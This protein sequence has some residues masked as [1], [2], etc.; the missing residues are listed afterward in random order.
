MS[1]KQLF[2]IFINSWRLVFVVFA[3]RFCSEKEK[4]DKAISAWNAVK[5]LPLKGEKAIAYYL[6]FYK[7]FRNLFLHRIR[8][9]CLVGIIKI[10]FPPMETL[11][12][13]CENIGSG[14][15]IQHGFSTIL[16]AKSV[17]ENC[18]LNQQVT[19]E[20]KGE[21]APVVEDNVKI[22]AGAIVIGDVRLEKGSV[23]GAGAVVTKNVGAGVTVAG[24]PAAV[25]KTRS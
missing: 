10:L 25:I 3:Y 13:A 17:G 14:L 8:R 20:Y 9:S 15:F 2:R 23:V 1:K 21:F 7:E 19:V 18:W 24:N 4:I 6:L 22:F 5:K 16:A 11:Y 12:L